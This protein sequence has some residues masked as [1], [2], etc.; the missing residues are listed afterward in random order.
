MSNQN[1]TF[2]KL[3]TPSL[4]MLHIKNILKLYECLYMIS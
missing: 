4:D 1:M 3:S 2:L